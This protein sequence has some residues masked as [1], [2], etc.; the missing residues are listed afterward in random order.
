MFLFSFLFTLY[1][2]S[3]WEG[4]KN[5]TK[6][7][8]PGLLADLPCNPHSYIVLVLILFVGVSPVFQGVNLGHFTVTFRCGNFPKLVLKYLSHCRCLIGWDIFEGLKQRSLFFISVFWKIVKLSTWYK[9]ISDLNQNKF[10]HS[11]SN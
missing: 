5:S 7:P 3:L 9:R 6:N 2:L 11:E 10:A 1:C 8:L 4:G